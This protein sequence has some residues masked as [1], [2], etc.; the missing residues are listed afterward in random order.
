MTIATHD[1]KEKVAAALVAGGSKVR[2]AGSC[3]WVLRISNGTAVKAQARLDDGWLHVTSPLGNKV[4]N[5]WKLLQLN[6]HLE[7]LSK[8]AS[9][10]FRDSRHLRAEIPCDPEIEL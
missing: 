2:Q 7:G 4:P 6:T 9:L 8:F 5:A 10:P 1:L 3:C